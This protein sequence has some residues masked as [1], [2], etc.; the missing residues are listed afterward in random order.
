MAT[1]GLLYNLGKYDAPEEGEPP[2]I[3]AEL[4]GES[5]VVAIAEALKWGGHNVVFVEGDEDAYTRLKESKIDIAFNICEGLR[6][7]SRESQI[8]AMLEALG[9]PYTGSGVLTLAIGLDKP[10][11]KKIFAYHGIPT[12]RFRVFDVFDEITSD[13]MSFP[14]FAKP[15]HEG[16][17]MGVSP[18]SVVR[19]ESELRYQV[20]YVRRFYKQAALVEEFLE[21]REFT[22]GIIGNRNP[23]CLPIR[24]I[25]YDHVPAEHG[26]VYSRQFKVEFDQEDKYYQCPADIT[27]DEAAAIRAVALDAYRVLD[28]RDVGRVDLRMDRDGRPNVLEVNPLPGLTPNFS[29]LCKA[30][31]AA[32]MGFNWLVNSILE[33]A[34]D[35]YDLKHLSS[36]VMQSGILAQ[37]A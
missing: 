6:G 35:R 25:L 13:G 9:I 36:P 15:A 18:S 21:G 26:K 27:E 31:E 16:S 3:N 22:V 33:A 7:E 8:P 30:A 34:I 11:A 23:M 20:D 29:D 10:I 2:D 17:S 4:D 32:G 5:T 24:E 37:T 1:V 14:L 19:N 28:C 12:P